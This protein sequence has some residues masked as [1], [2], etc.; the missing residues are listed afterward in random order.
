MKLCESVD[1][2][3]PSSEHNSFINY[4]SFDALSI[5]IPVLYILQL[6]VN[7]E[8][9]EAIAEEYRAHDNFALATVH[10]RLDQYCSHSLQSSISLPIPLFACPNFDDSLGER[11]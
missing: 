3:L 8:C 1:G 4:P 2:K 6:H 10:P 9:L 7:L 5:A 11:G